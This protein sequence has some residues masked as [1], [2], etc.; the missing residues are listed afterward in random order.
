MSDVVMRKSSLLKLCI[1]WILV[2]VTML[3]YIW[4]HQESTRITRKKTRITSPLVYL[5]TEILSSV[6]HLS[7]HTHGAYTFSHPKD[8]STYHFLSVITI[9]PM[10]LF[11]TILWKYPGF[12][13]ISSSHLSFQAYKTMKCPGTSFVNWKY[14]SSPLSHR[15][16]SKSI[17]GPESSSGWCLAI[18]K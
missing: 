3:T 16:T 9:D 17:I 15:A 18:D 10:V 5:T 1:T 12:R 11:H 13:S 14:F 7:L 2:M 4:T 8:A 6:G